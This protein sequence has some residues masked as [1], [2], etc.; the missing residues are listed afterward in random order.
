MMTLRNGKFFK[1]GNPYPL[2]FGNMDQINLIDAVKQLK[3]EGAVPILIFDER[4]TFISGL[5]LTCVCGS[6]ILLAWETEE[7]G[8]EI[9]GTEVK[10]PGCD[11]NYEVC[12]DEYNFLFFKIKEAKSRRK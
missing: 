2:E 11:F 5:Q 4:Q 12:A 1:D 6:E 7:E 3:E 8:Y 10:C 9:E